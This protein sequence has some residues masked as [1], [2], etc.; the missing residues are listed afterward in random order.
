[1]FN[2]LASSH[3]YYEEKKLSTTFNVFKMETTYKFTFKIYKI[4]KI[5]EY[6][7]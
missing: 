2:G 4:E 1:M 3:Y 7:F 6:F 5:A